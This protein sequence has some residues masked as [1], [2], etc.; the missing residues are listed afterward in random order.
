MYLSTTE[1]GGSIIWNIMPILLKKRTIIEGACSF[2]I[3]KS[4]KMS[5]WNA[6]KSLL[7]FRRNCINHKKSTSA[8]LKKSELQGDNISHKLQLEN[9][10]KSL[11]TATWLSN[12]AHS[13]RNDGSREPYNLELE[14]QSLCDSV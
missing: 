2:Y 10:S 3:L 7:N 4:T 1:T 6:T 14:N 5:P 13:Q 8:L 11:A 9:Q 12:D